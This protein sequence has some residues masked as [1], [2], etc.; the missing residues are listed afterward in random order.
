VFLGEDHV[1]ECCKIVMDGV[2]HKGTHSS[3]GFYLLIASGKGLYHQARR[4]AAVVGLVVILTAITASLSLRLAEQFGRLSV[5]P[6]YDDVEYFLAAARWLNAAPSHGFAANLY[7]LLHQHAPFSTLSAVIGF[8]LRPDSFLGPYAINAVIILVFLLGV[9]RLLWRCSLV[10]LVTCLAGAACVPMLWQTMTEARPDLPW[11]LALGLAIGALL[12]RPLLQR[13]RWSIFRLGLLCGLACAIKPSAVPASLACIG[14]AAGAQLA[15]EC[16]ES[17]IKTFR[18]AVARAGLPALLFAAGLLAG[19]VPIVGI[20]LVQTIRYILSVMIHDR[21]FWVIDESFRTSLMHYSIGFEGRL[22]L[23]Y[24]LWVGLA[25]V[26]A[27][28]CL[29]VLND[30]RDVGRACTILAA[31]LIAYAIPTL[32]N[33]KTYFLGAM[34]Y[35]VFIV[36]MTLNFGAVVAGLDAVISR[37]MPGTPLQR[38]LGLG[39]HLLPLAAVLSLFLV[40]CFPGR[41][42]LSTALTPD[43]IRDIRVATARVWSLLQER[44]QGVEASAQPGKVPVISFSSP[45]PVT[46]AAIQLYAVQARMPLDVRG[47]LFNRTLDAAEKALLASDVAI[48]TSSMPH[49]LPGPRMGDELIGRLDADPSMCLV[50]SLPLLTVRV[51]RIYRRGDPGCGASAPASR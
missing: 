38:W 33:V 22:A 48:V 12:Y 39:L 47:E 36:T 18:A 24:W 28:L 11:G 23:N 26:T 34:F 10:D 1:W 2:V 37:L 3:V 17:G 41:V 46:P 20:E 44:S 25:L 6:L 42:A 15:C 51:M 21:D 14:L 32:S 43:Q 19:A 30:R 31:G 4:V 13:S 27:R 35:G 5:P 9:A 45:Y 50:D 7:G 8:T 49:N 29:A 16:L 40:T